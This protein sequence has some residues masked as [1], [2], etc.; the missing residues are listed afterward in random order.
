MN[1]FDVFD[2]FAFVV[3]GVLLGAVVALVVIVGS[4]P[5]RIAATPQPP[6]SQ[7]DHGCRLD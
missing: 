7:G 5:G 3:F 1:Q 6:S 4:L 2:V